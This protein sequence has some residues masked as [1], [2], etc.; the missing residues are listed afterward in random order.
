MMIETTIALS[1]EVLA[2]LTEREPDPRL[3]SKFVEAAVRA[4]LLR[5]HRRDPSRDL[6]IINAHAEE[7]NREAEDVLSYQVIP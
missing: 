6:A 4:Y 7:L 2:A 5:L 3:R 1:E